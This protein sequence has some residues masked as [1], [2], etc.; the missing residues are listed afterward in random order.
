MI[1]ALGAKEREDAAADGR[2]SSERTCAVTRA[3]LPPECL[4]RFVASPDGVITPD[5]TRKLPGRGVWLSCH[6][7]VVAQATKT[8]A[9]A[10]SLRKKVQVPEDLDAKVDTLLARRVLDLLSMCNKAGL[11]AT[12]AGKVNSWLEAGAQGALVQAMD[13]SPG[14]LSKVAAKYRAIRKAIR[15]EPIEVALLTISELSLALGRSNVVHAALSEGTAARKFLA[16]FSRLEMYRAAE[17]EAPTL[18]DSSVRQDSVPVN[19]TG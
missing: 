11:V 17:F 4:I 1:R 6:A 5:I 3:V 13:A 8:G 10:R 18:M 9:F 12:G 7:P 14:G 2:T 19:I 16:A 15:R